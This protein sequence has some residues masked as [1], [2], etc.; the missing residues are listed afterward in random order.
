MEE[1]KTLRVLLI[2]DSENDAQL[3][4]REMRRFGYEVQYERVET[5]EALRNRLAKKEWDVILCDY[6]LPHLDAPRALEILQSTDLDLPFIIV[7]GSIGEENAVNAL[8][9][10]AHDF[11]IKGKYAR[12]APALEREIRAA[13]IRQDRRQAEETLREKER[14]LSE[15]Q[16]IGH[17]GSWSLDI[18]SD[19][20]QF[21]DEMYH[22]LDILPQE[23]EHTS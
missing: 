10:G 3:L 12:L 22:L 21:S 8:K 1:K 18:H 5:A 20:L 7:S 6:S 13:K 11:I 4:L 23:F 17:I 16:S 14:L 9:A 2:E 19:N 15:A